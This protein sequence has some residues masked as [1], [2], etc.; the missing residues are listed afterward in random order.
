MTS[1]QQCS[2]DTHVHLLHTYGAGQSLTKIHL[3]LSYLT[4]SGLLMMQFNLLEIGIMIPLSKMFNLMSKLDLITI[5]LLYI[6]YYSYRGKY[7]FILLPLMFIPRKLYFF[8]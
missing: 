2:K 3:R 4:N 5:F 7:A 1:M 8:L 6:Q